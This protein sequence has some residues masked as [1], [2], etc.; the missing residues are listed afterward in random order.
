MLCILNGF[1]ISG[2]SSLDQIIM[3]LGVSFECDFAIA[4]CAFEVEPE[5]LNAQVCLFVA[6][7]HTHVELGSNV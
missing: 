2:S 7:L 4:I 6:D 5:D 1:I 3:I